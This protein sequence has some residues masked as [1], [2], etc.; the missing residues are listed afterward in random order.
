M[1]FKII[2]PYLLF[3][4]TLLISGT[5]SGPEPKFTPEPR[6][7]TIL[8]A[9]IIDIIKYVPEQEDEKNARYLD[10]KADSLCNVYIKN[11]L[12]A[13]KKLKPL[14]GTKKYASAVRRELPGA[15]VGSHCLYGQSTHLARAQGMMGDTLKIIPE[16][17]KMACTNFKEKMRQEYANTPSCVYE[18][19]MHESDSAYKAALAK[20]LKRKNVTSKT[21]SAVRALYI[22]RFG[23]KN[24]VADELT[25]GSILIVPRHRGSRD[26]LHAIMYLGRGYVNRGNFSPDSAGQHIYVGHNR[27]NIG[28]LFRTYDTSNVFAADTRN[29]ARQK[30][31]QELNEIEA[32]SYNELVDFLTPNK[33]A[34]LA[35]VSRDR[36][37]HMARNKYFNMPLAPDNLMVN[38]LLAHS[39]LNNYKKNCFIYKTNM[40]KGR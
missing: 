26:A 30:Y 38:K 21:P 1:K 31:Q 9:K 23:Q 8:P 34:A 19:I 17:A 32:M 24:F 28:E 10:I 40:Q 15:P 18:G 6:K 2:V 14:V 36:L 22:E 12:S 37:L 16:D 7:Q 3:G 11:V 5:T 27:E 25:P 29:I 33:E 4:S 13:Q 20:Y 35:G 39:L